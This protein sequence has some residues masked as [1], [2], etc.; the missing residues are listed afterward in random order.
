LISPSYS[1]G[2]GIAANENEGTWTYRE[3]ASNS[4]GNSD[5][6]AESGSVK[7][8]RTPP[9]TPKLA[10][11]RLPDYAGGGGWYRDAVTVS[12]LDDGDPPLADSSSGSGVEQSTIPAARTITAAG[13]TPISATVEDNVGNESASA[14]LIVQV[15][16]TAP[17]LSVSCPTAV[18]LHANATAVTSA[19]DTGS[20]LFSDPS[21][22]T[23]IDTSTAGTKTIS[24][25]A[26]DNVGHAVTKTC[27]TQVQYMYSGLQQPVNPDGSSIFKLGS[28]LPLKLQLTDIGGA[29]VDGVVARVYVAAISGSVEGTYL[30][31]VSSSAADSGNQFRETTPGGYV[32]NFSTKSLSKGTWEVIVVLD[33]QTSYKSLISLK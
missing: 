30:E 9:R 23:A 15:D 21:G 8:D 10:A 1:F 26:T 22:T 11:D 33:D 27:T 28:T 4:A 24:E 3:T 29:S 13:E 25:T 16:T 5:P 31:A 19:V 18:L 20:G 17:N 12:T 6:S 14:S 2:F 7:V 32:F